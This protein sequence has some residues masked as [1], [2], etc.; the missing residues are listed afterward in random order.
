MECGRKT[1]CG[2]IAAK[3]S[4]GR[5]G[6]TGRRARKW[7]GANGRRSAGRRRSTNGSYGTDTGYST[8]ARHAAGAG[9]RRSTNNRH[10]AGTGCRRS[11]NGWHA[12]GSRCSATSKQC[13]GR[14]SARGGWSECQCFGNAFYAGADNFNHS[15]QAVGRSALGYDRRVQL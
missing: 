9:C 11:T 1:C 6:G 8:N 4:D 7:N 14:R 5:T 15:A 10:A 12:A 2:G 3:Y 13:A